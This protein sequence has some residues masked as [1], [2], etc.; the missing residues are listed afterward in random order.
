MPKSP[1]WRGQ[2]G[3][4]PNRPIPCGSKLW[5]PQG[6]PVFY[7]VGHIHMYHLQMISLKTYI[8]QRYPHASLH[9]KTT[10]ICTYPLH[11]LKAQTKGIGWWARLVHIKTLP[12][13]LNL[14]GDI[15]T[16]NIPQSIYSQ[17]ARGFISS[18]CRHCV[19]TSSQSS[20]QM[21]PV[22]HSNKVLQAQALL[23]HP[24]TNFQN[25]RLTFNNV[26]SALP[27]LHV[28]FLLAL[29]GRQV[30]QAWQLWSVDLAL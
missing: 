22:N 24:P 13:M 2:I 19:R 9:S 11:L 20:W 10:H 3:H 6:K 29:A 21:L 8:L 15:V 7:D 5:Q 18:A 25:V 26:G 23:L 4:V 14:I 28:W 1:P 12:G 30:Q 27:P 17:A 16:S